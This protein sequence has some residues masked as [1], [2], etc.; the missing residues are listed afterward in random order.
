MNEKRS[1]FITEPPEDPG[2]LFVKLDAA[3]RGLR[4]FSLISAAV[5]LGIFDVCTT[6]VTAQELASRISSDV[7]MCGLLCEALVMEGLLTLENGNY[8]DTTLASTYLI[9]SSPYSQ[10]HYIRQLAR[11]GED[12]WSPL[13]HIIHNGPKQYDKEI[14]FREYSLP[15]MAE[16]A[17]SGRLQAVILAVI[18]LPGFD[19]V[20]RVLDLGGGHGL[21]AIA[22][23][24]QRPDI[25]AWVFDLPHV[26]TLAGQYLEQYNAENVHLLPGD[27]FSDSFGDGYDLIISSSNPSGKSIELLPKISGALNKGGYFIT[28]QSPGGLPHD[29]FQTLEYKLWTFQGV[30]KLHGGFTKEKAFM[31]P[32]YR[33]ALSENG[34]VIIDERDIRDHYHEDTWVRMVITRKITGGEEIIAKMPEQV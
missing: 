27:F 21:Y 24:M 20:K 15:A 18:S 26:V 29:P 8:S 23:G 12:L 11:M 9:I 14:F 16:N 2:L 10:V 17:L 6:P 25:E 28:I 3:I 34:L 31:T 4:E 22:L 32:E 7:E 1:F 13:A 33:H 19:S 30:N 5:E